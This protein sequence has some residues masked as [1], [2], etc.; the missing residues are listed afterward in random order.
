MLARAFFTC[1]LLLALPGCALLSWGCPERGELPQESVQAMGVRRVV[2]NA[3]TGSLRVEGRPGLSEV[4]VNGEICTADRKLLPAFGLVAER[5]RDTVLVR[6]ILPDVSYR[7]ASLDV[8]V[9]VPDDVSVSIRDSRGWLLVAGVLSVD[10]RDGRGD[11]L[12]EDIGGDV[13]VTDGDGDIE[14]T[15][16]AG[17]VRVFDGAGDLTIADVQGTVTLE[18]KTEGHVDIED[19]RGDVTIWSHGHGDIDVSWIDGGLTVVSHKSG[20]LSHSRVA[21]RVLLPED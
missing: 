8:V 3:G 2:V 5:T 18:E 17:D 9:E 16:V 12:L 20:D 10:V 4:R 7:D 21:G 19:V 14:I 11:I 1:A 13:R 15:G 6:A